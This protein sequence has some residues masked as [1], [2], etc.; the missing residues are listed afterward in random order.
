MYLSIALQATC[1]AVN[2]CSTVP[3]ARDR[4]I[5]NIK[6]V[7]AQVRASKNFLGSRVKLVVLPEY[8]ATGFPMG[9]SIEAWQLKACFEVGG[10]EYDL[11]SEI[12]TQNSCFLSGNCY[13]LD[14]AFPNLYFQTSFIIDDEGK[15]IVRYRRLISMFSPTPHDVLDEYLSV[16]GA[17]SLF[18]VAKTSIG[19]LACVASE[20]ILFPEITRALM[21][22]GAEVI[23]HS[24]SEVGSVLATPKHIAKLARAYENHCYIVSANSAAIT[25]TNFPAHSTD[26]NSCVIDF[27]GKTLGQSGYGESMAAHGYISIENLREYRNQPSMFNLISRLRLELFKETYQ[28][29][30]FPPNSFLKNQS[31]Q[32]VKNNALETQKQVIEDL[33]NRGILV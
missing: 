12:A 16:Y 2:Q 30:I 6:K 17:L 13:E 32:V 15:L 4:I 23:C 3:D 22:Q 28:K 5:D 29:T 33:I 14:A 11:L 7:G 24:S 1:N 9:D 31:G 18:P 21:L 25:N 26:G 19:N 20:E 27:L 10:E 8:F